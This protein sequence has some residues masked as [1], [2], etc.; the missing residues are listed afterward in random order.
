MSSDPPVPALATALPWHREELESV[1]AEGQRA[2]HALL[3]CGSRGEG[4]TQFALALAAALLCED[5]ATDGSACGRCASCRWFAAGNHPDCRWIRPEAEDP[6]FE[7]SRSAKPSREI[8]IGQVR[9]ISAF[10]SIGAHRGGEKVIIVETVDALNSIAANAMLKILEEPPG[11]SRFLLVAERPDLLLPTISSRCRRVVLRPP[12]DRAALE[13]LLAHGDVG[14][15]EAGLAL[16]AAGGEPLLALAI[17]E[18]R[19]AAAH[20]LVLEALE[21]LPETSPVRTAEQL[22][23]LEPGKWLPLTQAWVADLARVSGG[24]EPRFLPRYVERLTRLAGRTGLGAILEVEPS[25]VACGARS[26]IRSIRVCSA[27]VLLRYC[28]LFEPN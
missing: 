16:A 14:R 17:A 7:P 2:H 9:A 23:R 20:R 3:I 19:E 21:A 15:E 18:P 6:L 1:L 5:P 27:S 12:S 10:A 24:A 11:R 28:E 13:W 8:K 25:F 22:S 26:T 4:A